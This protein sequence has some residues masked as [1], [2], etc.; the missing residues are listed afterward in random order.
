MTQ[1]RGAALTIT[2][3][4]ALI[5]AIALYAILMMASSQARQAAFTASRLRAR[6]AAEIGLVWAQQRLRDNPAYCGDPDP[7]VVGGVAID[8]VMTD[9]GTPN[10]KIAV[11]VT[12]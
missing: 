4:I 10:P 1:E 12:Q 7:P 5:T 3:M 2:I 11:V 9:C 6:Y 8:V